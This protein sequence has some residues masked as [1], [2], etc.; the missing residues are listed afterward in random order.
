ML[1][2]GVGWGWVE[3]VDGWMDAVTLHYWEITG[4]T[5]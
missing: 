3:L 1:V 4:L 5:R 2:G